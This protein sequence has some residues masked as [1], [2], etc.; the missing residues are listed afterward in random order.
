MP[1]PNRPSTIAD[2]GWITSTEKPTPDTKPRQDSKH[3]KDSQAVLNRL[4][5]QESVPS[6]TSPPEPVSQ[7]NVDIPTSL[8]S[9]LHSVVGWDE[10]RRSLKEIVSLILAEG[11]AKF[12]DRGPAPPSY[13]NR[14]KSFGKRKT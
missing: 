14:L 7:L 4:L 12:P 1:S 2:L 6:Q 5:I 13:L 9:R 10:E 8:L 3:S 11:L